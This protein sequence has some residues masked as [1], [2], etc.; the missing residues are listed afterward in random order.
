[1]F[2]VLPGF[3]PN[4]SL[5]P[6]HLKLSA[7]PLLQLDRAFFFCFFFFFFFYSV[8]FLSTFFFE[9]SMLTR[10]IVVSLP[11]GGK[12]EEGNLSPADRL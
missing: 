11:L 5:S 2:V 7:F 4:L 12:V 1:L 10:Q 9:H 6:E 8:F 3:V